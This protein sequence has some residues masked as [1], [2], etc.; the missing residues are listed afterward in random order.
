MF[1]I[2]ILSVINSFGFW[3][4]GVPSPLFWGIMVS[5]LNVIPYVGPIIGF[6][7]V[8][9]FSLIVAGPT[10]ALL[11]IVMF[12]VAQFIDNNFLTPIIAGGQIEINPLASI[13]SIVF[14][15]MLW[16]IIGMVIAL[17]ILGL[18]KIICDTIP[19]LRP[20]GYLLGDKE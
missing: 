18:F 13:I 20:I 6:S 12:L 15:G 11:A 7:S 16:G 19:G 17:P 14:W 5:L 10:V 8:A 4:I 9:I 3:I 2:G 1:V